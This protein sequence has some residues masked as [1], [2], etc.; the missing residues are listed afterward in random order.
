MNYLT[1]SAIIG[2]GAALG[3]PPLLQW[4][5]PLIGVGFLLVSLGAWRFGE[6]HYRS[7]GS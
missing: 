5:A 3:V 2:R 7:T 1:A 6:R 4:T